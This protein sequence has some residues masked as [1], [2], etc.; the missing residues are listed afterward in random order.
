M[1]GSAAVTPPVAFDNADRVIDIERALGLYHG[2]GRPGGLPRRGQ[3]SSAFWNIFYGTAHFVVTARGMVWLFLRHPARYRSGATCWPAPPRSPSSASA[4]F[5]LMPPRLLPP[6]ARRS[7]SST[8]SA[9][10]AVCGRSIRRP[11]RR[12]E[13]VRGDAEPALR[14][15]A[16]VR[17]AV[18]PT[19]RSR[20]C[21]AARHLPGHDPVRDRRDREPL[22]ARRTRRSP[23][24]RLLGLHRPAA[25]HPAA[26]PRWRARRTTVDATSVRDRWPAE[27]DTEPAPRARAARLG[28]RRRRGTGPC[29]RA[30]RVAAGTKTAPGVACSSLYGPRL[31]RKDD[32]AMLLESISEPRRPRAL[33]ADELDELAAE[34]RQF[35]VD[36]VSRA[37]RAP[38]VQP[39]RGRAHARPAPGVRLAPRHHPVGHR[40]PGLRPQA[41]HRAASTAST[42]SA[43]GRRPVGLPEPGRVR[44]RLDREQP[45]VDRAELRLRHRHRRRARGPRPAGR[46]RHRRRLDDRRHGVRG[47]QQPRP[48]RAD[49]IIILNDNGRSYAPT[50][51][52]LGES[53]GPHPAE[54]HL[55]A[56]PAQARA[57][58]PG[59]AGGRRARSSRASTAPRRRCGRCWSRTAFFETLGVRYTGPFDGHDIERA[60][61]GPAPG[62]RVRG[63]D[64]RARAHP[65]GPGLRR[66]PRTTRSSACTTSVRRVQ[67]RLVHRGL[68]R[69]ARSPP[70][71]ATRRSWPSPPPC[72]TPPA[73]CRS[74]SASPTVCFDVGIAEQHAV[75]AAAGMAMG[76]L[77]PV[78]AVYSTFLTR[79]FDQVNLDV[80]LHGQPV[81]LLPRPGRHH[82]RRRRLAPR[83]AR[84]GAAHQG[85][86]HDG[87]RAVVVPG[88]RR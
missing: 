66:R 16:V 53:L 44:A 10:S 39:G 79:A 9:R 1:F 31:R 19:F 88:A 80:G 13:P 70:P 77:R 68:H 8:R 65:E 17:L 81:R 63:A 85:P 2:G 24:C 84:H 3:A 67:A 71:S 29:Q 33:D 38:R 59:R 83:R 54:P 21:D 27:T 61:D 87:V 58:A 11:A 49:V 5:P 30:S 57:A 86:G 69:G 64:R 22:L 41:R 74:P 26:G 7:A 18:F 28:T 73:C 55:H 37:E 35:I 48:Q 56:A 72:P 45:R 23:G 6:S 40:P 82:R 47:P 75:T 14:L 20:P 60:R 34:I 36:T 43:P 50:V 62:R 32:H 15:V 46:R 12:V 4:P 76:G 78:V 42:R 25:H 52:Q 51:S